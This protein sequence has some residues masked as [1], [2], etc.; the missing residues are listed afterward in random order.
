MQRLQQSTC[1]GRRA[2]ASRVATARSD[3]TLPRIQVPRGCGHDLELR[4][5]QRHVSLSESPAANRPIINRL[6]MSLA[7]P[8]WSQAA[9][10]ECRDGFG[11]G[12]WA[13]CIWRDV[14]AT[15]ALR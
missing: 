1:Q 14:H 4:R 15:I 3:V 13:R 9:E 6:F 7:L 11:A 12:T 5:D 8:S 10:P 2:S